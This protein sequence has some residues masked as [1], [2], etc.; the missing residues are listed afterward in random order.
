MVPISLAHSSPSF[1]NS[2]HLQVLAQAYSQATDASGTELS[3]PGLLGQPVF[4]DNFH[5]SPSVL[6]SF[7][8]M[9]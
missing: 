6:K 2:S 5:C 8:F 1:F 7:S 3:H 9:L 4:M